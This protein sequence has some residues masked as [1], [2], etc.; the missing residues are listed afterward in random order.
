MCVHLCT[1]MTGLWVRIPATA[2]KSLFHLHFIQPYPALVIDISGGSSGGNWVIQ[3]WYSVWPIYRP[4]QETCRRHG[5]VLVSACCTPQ[6][7]SFE[8]RRYVY[9]SFYAPSIS[10]E[11]LKSSGLSFL[12]YCYFLNGYVCVPKNDF[13]ARAYFEK[14]QYLTNALIYCIIK[15]EPTLL[16]TSLL[17]NYVAQV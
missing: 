2:W 8:L 11:N 1:L 7:V 17:P 9:D 3:V 16:F 15:V 6:C 13:F 12:R 5:F 14:E 4:M 10:C